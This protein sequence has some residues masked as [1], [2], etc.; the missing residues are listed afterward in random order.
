[1]AVHTYLQSIE[2]A[3]RGR[4]ERKAVASSDGGGG[5]GG[6][7]NTHCSASV[8]ENS[9]DMA[10]LVD[11]KQAI[12]KD[13]SGVL[14]SWNT[15]MP[16]CQWMGVACSRRHPGRVAALQL[17]GQS[18]TGIL[19]PSLGNLTFL[20]ALNLSSNY[21]SGHL[22]HL[23]HLYRLEVLDPS[24]NLLQGVIPDTL[25]NCSNLRSIYLAY[26]FL[27]GE[28]PLNVGLLPELSTLYLSENNLTGT[29]P[30]TLNNT[31]LRVDSHSP[32]FNL[33]YLGGL[34][35]GMN[36]LGGELPSYIGDVLPNLQVLVLGGNMFAD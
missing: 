18:L 36:M 28:I 27:E 32:L 3:G 6:L 9:K 20:R 2:K 14:N 26:N 5:G 23:Q 35:L 8:P 4:R 19:T 7:R 33:S 13:P 11:F 1:M 25:T 17:G 30:P 16:F 34:D 29:I 31:R 12:T 21:F 24:S 22:P 10:S 15:S